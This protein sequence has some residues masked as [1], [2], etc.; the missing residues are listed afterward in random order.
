[1]AGFFQYVYSPI[2]NITFLIN[3]QFTDCKHHIFDQSTIYHF[4]HGYFNCLWTIYSYNLCEDVGHLNLH[5]TR[6][7][8]EGK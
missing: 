4:L 7:F 2:V 6:L 1:M 3:Q 5:G 8:V